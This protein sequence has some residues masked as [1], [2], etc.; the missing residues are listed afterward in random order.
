MGHQWASLV[1]AFVDFSCVYDGDTHV[2]ARGRHAGF[3][4]QGAFQAI[5]RC[6][7]QAVR[8]FALAFALARFLQSKWLRVCGSCRQDEL[9]RTHVHVAG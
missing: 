7:F 2:S 1:E 3:G 9:S 8:F 5:S 6:L 4:L